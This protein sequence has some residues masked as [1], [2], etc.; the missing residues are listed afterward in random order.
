[1]SVDSGD[2]RPSATETYAGWTATARLI[3]DNGAEVTVWHKWRSPPVT[4]G[5]Y[6]L[7]GAWRCHG[8]GRSDLPG[9]AKQ[10][11][12]RALRRLPTVPT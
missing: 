5:A 10:V 12:R 9:S 7:Q 8:L 3:P 11:G 2:G 6:V 4:F 1:M